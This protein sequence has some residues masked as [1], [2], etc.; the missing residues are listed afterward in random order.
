MCVYYK[1]AWLLL[2]IEDFKNYWAGL[3]F[4]DISDL[5]KVVIHPFN[6]VPQY[7]LP[8]PY[9]LQATIVDQSIKLTW[10][11]NT[12]NEGGFWISRKVDNN[13]WDPYYALIKNPNQTQYYDNNVSEHI[14]KYKISAISAD[15]SESST[16]VT[17]QGPPNAPSGLTVVGQPTPN[18][19]KLQWTDN[20]QIEA[21]FWIARATDGVWKEFYNDTFANITTYLDTVSFL[22]KYAHKVRAVD[23]AG[24]YSAWSNVVEF[25]CGTIAQSNYSRMSAFNN[26]AKVLR[27]PDGKIHITYADISSSGWKLYYTFTSDGYTFR[28]WKDLF[29]L[30]PY[31]SISNP[32]LAINNNGQPLVGYC[33]TGYLGGGAYRFYVGIKDTTPNPPAILL[34]WDGFA[35]SYSHPSFVW[36]ADTSWIVFRTSQPNYL[37]LTS[38]PS[39]SYGNYRIITTAGG[40]GNPVI[41]YD[42]AGRLVILS[43]TAAY[44]GIRLWFRTIDSSSWSS[45]INISN[46][47]AYGEPSLWTGTNELR[48]TFEGAYGNTWG[49]IFIQL[50]WNGSTYA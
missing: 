8:I 39:A 42:K 31:N 50:N 44:G 35:G 17:I 38:H 20:S 40:V 11:E 45:P 47:Y 10:A 12:I 43:H 34:Y 19:V 23:N 13:E 28:E 14:Y 25:V 36:A 4:P 49:I 24:H 32:A 15:T 9:N 33:A 3:N 1:C 18:Q 48:I 37:Y 21:K 16:E 27:G 30:L 2:D 46:A 22:H 7:D 41:G 26:G 6:Y 29:P 5:Y